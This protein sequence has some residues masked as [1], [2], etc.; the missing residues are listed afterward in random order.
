MRTFMSGVP[1]RDY[2]FQTEPY[3]EQI[4][5]AAKLIREADYILFGLGAGISTA[6]GA[7]YGGDF[8]KR[9]FGEFIEKYGA[10]PYMQDMYSAGFYPYPDEESY[11]GYW[12]RQAMVGGIELDV[13]GLY[14]QLIALAQ[15]KKS[16]CLSTNADGQMEKA[17]YPTEQIFCTQG[18]YFHIQCAKGCHAKTYDAVA[19]FRQMDQARRDCKVPFYMVPKCPVCGGKMN[20]NLR[21]DQYFVEDE[22]WYDA[23]ERFQKFLREALKS[24]KNFCLIDCG[25]G[26]NTPMIIRFPFEKMVREHGQCAMVR[27]NLNEAV[28]QESC[29]EREVGINADMAKSIPDILKTMNL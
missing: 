8:F 15:G 19:R 21:I 14:R 20:M 24:G 2:I 18:D 11:W 3:E 26:F 29:E 23:D 5:K 27:L 7:Q 12:S 1:A 10:G 17:G 22:A 16:F 6:A 28:V 25:T 4:K 13:T 9:N